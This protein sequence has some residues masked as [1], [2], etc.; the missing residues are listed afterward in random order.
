[1]TFDICE[2][3]LGRTPEN[4]QVT[5]EKDVFCTLIGKSKSDFVTEYMCITG[6]HI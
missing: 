1:M 2:F 4:K 5:T 6:V 3:V